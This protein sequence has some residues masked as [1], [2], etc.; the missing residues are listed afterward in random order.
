MCDL[1]G[2]PYVS[3]DEMDTE[4]ISS[5]IGGMDPKPQ[6]ILTTIS[7]VSEEAVQKQLRRLPIRTICLDE[8]QVHWQW[9][10]IRLNFEPQFE[11]KLIQPIDIH[12]LH[13]DVKIEGDQFW[14]EHWMGRVP[15]V[16]V[17]LKSLKHGQESRQKKP[18]Y[19][20]VRL[21]V[22]VDPPLHH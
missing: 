6:V 17:K 11:H 19:F 16:L 2:I 20:T 8:V 14:S 5:V 22:R 3:L 12:D 10:W 18:G 7:R 1:W 21:T 15:S 4:D 9:S 13:Y